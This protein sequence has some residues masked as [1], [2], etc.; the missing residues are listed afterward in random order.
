MYQ[1][2]QKLAVQGG[3]SLDLTYGLDGQ[4]EEIKDEKVGRIEMKFL[5]EKYGRILMDKILNDKTNLKR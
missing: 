5:R 1:Q 3:Y 2:K 4:S